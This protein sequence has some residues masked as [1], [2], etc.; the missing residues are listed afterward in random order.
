MIDFHEEDAGLSIP[1]PPLLPMDAC[2]LINLYATTRVSDLLQA[3]GAHVVL[4]E[5]VAAETLYVL[6]PVEGALAHSPIDI[7][8]EIQ[9]GLIIRTT[10]VEA[11]LAAFVRYATDLDDGEAATIALAIHRAGRIATD[12]RAAIN[13]IERNRLALT[14]V[15][16]SDLVRQWMNTSG[17]PRVEVASVLAEI[18]D[19]GRFMPNDSDPNLQWWQSV[20]QNQL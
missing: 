18:R 14:V 4:V 5:Q 11:E 17:V 10:L 13:Y 2:V 6:R 19:C 1:H 8:P 12:D 20:L 15:R 3:I 7:T 9:S 16:T